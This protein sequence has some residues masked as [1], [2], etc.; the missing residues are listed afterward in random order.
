MENVKQEVFKERMIDVYNRIKDITSFLPTSIRTVLEKELNTMKELI[1]DARPPRFA[2]VGRRGAGKSSLLNAIFGTKLAEIG[3]VKAKTIIGKWYS[4]EQSKGKMEIL[5][6]RGLE[7]GTNPEE[8]LSDYKKCLD[9]KLP[10]VFLFLCKAK[11]VDAH[12]NDDIENLIELYEYVKNKYDYEI[13]IVTIVTQSDEVDDIMDKTPPYETKKE[14]YINVAKMHLHDLVIRKVPNSIYS[15]AVSEHIKFD[16]NGNIITDSRWHIN[17]LLDLL[18]KHIP[19]S[20]QLELAK[21]GQMKSLQKSMAKKIVGISAAICSAIAAE[22]IPGIDLP[23][24]TGVQLSMIIGIGY[25]GGYN[26]DKE[27]AIK[28]LTAMGI[29]IGAAFVFREIARAI[30]K[31]IPVF[32]NIV[33]MGMAAAGTYSIGAAAIAY[34]IDKKSEDESKTIL[35]DGLGKIKE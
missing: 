35:N 25:I 28:F 21:I 31:L 12:I 9:E 13:P 17:E 18:L 19:E 24:I 10:D 32:G 22:P 11:E 26:M 16:D 30:I 27:T 34:L 14:E 4:Y 7:E 20:A 5:D 33:S 29:N 2:F 6:T 8:A 23:F 3:P 1:I 15:I